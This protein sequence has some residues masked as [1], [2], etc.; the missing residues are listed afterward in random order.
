MEDLNRFKPVLGYEDR[1]LVSDTGEVY[2]AYSQRLLKLTKNEAGYLKASLSKNGKCR[3][4]LRH[5]LVWEAFNGAIPNK[6]QINHRNGVRHD[7]DLRNLE[8]MTAR[9]NNQ[10]AINIGKRSYYGYPLLGVDLPE[11][12]DIQRKSRLEKYTIEELMLEY[13]LK[14]H[15]I[16][17]ILECK[18]SI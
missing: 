5:R 14:E 16:Q 17:R 9:E 4:Y 6:M 2:S 8:V 11:A 15:Q 1:Y 7:N 3:Q 13:M 10:H 12:I 18:L